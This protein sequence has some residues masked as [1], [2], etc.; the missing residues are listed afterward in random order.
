M[1]AIVWIVTS[2]HDM[3][4]TLLSEGHYTSVMIGVVSTVWCLCLAALLV[5]W[6]RRAAFRDR[7]LADGG[8]VRVAVRH[9]I[10]GDR[11]RREIRSRLLSR[12][13][14]RL[15]AAS[16]VLA[17][18]LFDNVA[19][20]GPAVPPARKT[21]P[22]G[23]FRREPSHRTRTA[24]QRGRQILPRCHHH[25]WGWTAPSRL[26]QGRRTDVRIYAA[27]A[28]GNSI[29]IVNPPEIRDEPRPMPRSGSRGEPSSNHETSRLRK[30]G[31]RLDVS[32][33]I[34]PIRSA[35]GEI[36]GASTIARDITERK[37]ASG[38][39]ARRSRSGA[40][41]SRPRRT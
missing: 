11:Q 30:D 4:P 18:L 22:P 21:E 15:C 14:L 27:E 26:E 17:V 28:I 32:L 38:R 33:V 6:L 8:A 36:V 1:I 24:V 31:S 5:L 2:G 39:S 3:L 12:P 9:R 37:R 10:V 23:G 19:L 25:S 7:R 13:D 34:S 41:S 20:A 40:A 29:D 35:S 16:F